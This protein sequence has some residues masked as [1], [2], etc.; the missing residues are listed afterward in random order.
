MG[1]GG[2]AKVCICRS[3]NH[4]DCVVRIPVVVGNNIQ[5]RLI[6]MMVTMDRIPGVV[7]Q[8]YKTS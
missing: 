4:G 5:Y 1:L 7:G 2:G 6:W 8:L 3:A